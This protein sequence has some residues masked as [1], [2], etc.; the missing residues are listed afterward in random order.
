MPG[1]IFFIDDNIYTNYI[2]LS[3]GAVSKEEIISGIQVIE[4][5][6]K[7]R[8]NKDNNKYLPFI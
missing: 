6:L 7:K 5:S 1:K 2:R 3:F 4:N 8:Q